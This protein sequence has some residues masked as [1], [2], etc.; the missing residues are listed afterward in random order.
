VAALKGVEVFRS[1]DQ[2]AVIREVRIELQPH[3]DVIHD[4]TL[5]S[6]ASNLSCNNRRTILRGQETGQWLS[7][8][9]SVVNGT[10]LSA[11]EY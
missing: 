4:S 6:I 7:V 1:S 9:P 10:Q 5:A 2:L 11:Q 3:K 8:M